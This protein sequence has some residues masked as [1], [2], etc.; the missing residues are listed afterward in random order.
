[1]KRFSAALAVV[2]LVLVWPLT[3]A[4]QEIISSFHSVI[5]L[6]KDGTLTVTETI[7]ANVEG[8][9]IR[10]GIYRDFPLTFA[11][12]RGRRSK[13]DFDLISVERDG[14]EENYRTEPIDGGIRIY[15]GEA[16]VF[17]PRGEHTFQITYETSRQIRFFDDH[18]E[19]YWNV[20]GTEWAFPIEEASATVTLP[21][22]LKSEAL[23]VFTGGYGATGKDARAVEE[24]DEIFFATT[25]RLRP[26]EGLTIAV[27]LPKG[28]ID[29]PS[30]SQQNIWWLRDHLALV[31]AAAGLVLVTLYYGRAWVRIGR[32][33]ERGVMVPRW[34]APED[35]SP[36]LVN[37]IDNKGLSGEG[38]TA[39][40]AAALNL[41]VKGHVVLD[42]LK[43]AIIITATGKGG[44]EKLP[45]GEATLMKA[46]ATAGGKLTIDRANGKKV[47]A[48]GSA[49]RSSMERE[50]RGKYYR[51]NTAYI[52]GGVL[53]S[54]LALA[55]LFIFGDLNEES[56]PLVIVP[57]FIAFF[58][59]IFAVSFGKSFR[60]GSSLARRIMS[61]V[62]LAFFAFVF[63]MIFSGVLAA[64]V[65]S[66]TGADD[67]PLLIAVGGIV[68]VNVLFFFLMGAPTP[69]GTRMMDGIDGLRQYMTLA[70]K[71]RMNLQGAPEMS[72]RHFE[73]LLPYAVALGVEKPWT[74]T[75]DRWLLAASAGAAA[76]AAYQPSWY[77]GDSFGP[78][79]FGD[80]IGG[81]AGSM[82]DTMTSSLPPPPKSSS[83]GFSSGG[84][85]SGGGGGGGGGGGW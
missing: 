44:A 73:T 12:A 51:A 15:T 8:N 29:R 7:T 20:T 1:M 6:A 28:S 70:E 68:L 60:R 43:K 16:D 66:A 77:H 5:D 63:L 47:E 79:S 13:V 74:E 17:L 35:I 55:A 2:L 39:L 37:Y 50:H 34:D 30:P 83:S 46:I 38:W 48:A 49:F 65:F 45:T 24:G 10:R 82:A 76:A 58:V 78:G 18:D 3:A 71:D 59:S 67:L 85:F 19:L 40:S 23:D 69:L 61:I 41:A 81:F 57:V 42:D 26:Q 4:A 84:G 9:Q 75:F 27:K 80:R 31:I 54:V 53:L 36:A 11:D 52:V 21:E 72:P 33:P 62:V 25:R 14:E 64:I 22:G 56:I 32:D